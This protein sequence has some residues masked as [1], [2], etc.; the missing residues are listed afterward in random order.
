MTQ[1]K[2]LEIISA[3][4][5]LNTSCT[6]IQLHGVICSFQLAMWHIFLFKI[7]LTLLCHQVIPFY[8]L[9]SK[10]STSTIRKQKNKP[11]KKLNQNKNVKSIKS[12]LT[13]QTPTRCWCWSILVLV[14]LVNGVGQIKPTPTNIRTVCKAENQNEISCFSLYTSSTTG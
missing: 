5:T 1:G 8:G 9:L 13:N 10:T 4:M 2:L 12:H 7:S 14:K 11:K 3:Q 6:V